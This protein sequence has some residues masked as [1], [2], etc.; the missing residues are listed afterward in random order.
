MIVSRDARIAHSSPGA[1]GRR[2]SF[3]IDVLRFESR[4]RRVADTEGRVGLRRFGS[5]SARDSL[6]TRRARASA[7]FRL[8]DLV[9]LAE[10][11]TTAPSFSDILIRAQSGRLAEP[12]TSRVASALVCEVLTCW[13]PGPLEVEK[14]HT[15]SAVSSSTPAARRSFAGP[16]ELIATPSGTALGATIG[17]VPA[18]SVA[19]VS[20]F[21][22]SRRRRSGSF[23]VAVRSV[24]RRRR[25]QGTLTYAR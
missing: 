4:R 8:W 16:S 25:C 10:L 19:P 11:D 21:V 18:G 7:R 9:S 15:I 14:R 1:G 24:C 5:S 17:T 12:V 22:P 13:P 3:F 2:A 6:A 20:R 23:R